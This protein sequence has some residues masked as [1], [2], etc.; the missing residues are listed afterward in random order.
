MRSRGILLAACAAS[1]LMPVSGHTQT[2]AAN[3]AEVEATGGLAEIVVTAQKR[4]E[5]AQRVPIAISAF[6]S[7]A[8]QAKGVTELTQI[9]QLAPNV[10]LDSGTPFSGSSSTL[11]AYIRG[12]GQNDFAL[13]LDPGVGIY[14]DGVYLARTVGANADLAD[15]ERVEILKGPQGTL[16]GRNSIGGAISIVTRAP[17]KE[18]GV[19]GSITTG[20]YDRLDVSLSADLPI[21]ETLRSNLTF[22]SRKRDG[23]QR[24]IPLPTT[25][26]YI[27]DGDGFRHAGYDRSSTQGGTNEWTARGKLL[28]EAAPSLRLTLAGDYTK[29]DQQ[30]SAQSLLKVYSSAEVAALGAGAGLPFGALTPS[31]PSANNFVEIYNRC[32]SETPAQLARPVFAPFPPGFVDLTAVC[33]ERGVPA[34]ARNPLGRTSVTSALGS[35]NVDADPGNNRLPYDNRFIA[36]NI[37]QTYANGL[38]FSKLRSWG[39]SGTADFNLSDHA[40]LKSITAYREL[41]WSTGGDQD[42]SP[43]QILEFSF[44]INQQQFSQELQ[45]TGDLMDGRLK[46]VFGGYYFRESGNNQDYVTLPGGL[47]Q[48]DGNNLL[49]TKSYAG[50]THLNFDSTDWLSFTAGA[51][52]SVER[53]SFEGF[54]TELN[55]FNYKLGGIPINGLINVPCD[56][57]GPVPPSDICD[58]AQLVGFPDA[59]NVL[60]YVPPVVFRKKFNIFTPRLGF[61][62]K[63]STRLMV[64]GSYSKGFKSGGWTTRFNNPTPFQT[65]SDGFGPERAT[66]WELGVKSEWLNRHLLVNVSGFYTNYDGIQLTT[67]VNGVTATAR[68][69]GDAELYGV[70]VESRAVI[71]RAFSIAANI[72]YIHARYTRKL[73]GTNAGD[74]LPKTP[75]FKFNIGPQYVADLG[76]KGSLTF[77]ADYTHT[78]SEFNNTENSAILTRPGVDMLNASITYNSPDRHWSLT[79]GASNILDQRYITTGFDNPGIGLAAGTY[80]A[81]RQWY[82]TLGVKF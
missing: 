14:L 19:R 73:P 50:Y 22:S 45:L 58:F 65:V 5:S 42:G 35:V 40:A 62:I 4:S 69:A 2:A 66:S 11:A 21:S 49:R 37:D 67:L 8:L 76:D 29:Q 13:N 41:K 27:T 10:S 56:N 63:P 43:L 82:A 9:A 47:Q 51:R 71:S 6:T 52:Y 80:S 23:Y 74:R 44:E 53:K 38:S 33:G 57:A 59:N 31:G 60:R 18:F 20:S 28:W 30:G 68:N 25:A 7:D 55:G 79:G 15:V 39:L 78:S 24:R 77:S 26:A 34:G 32:I 72:G 61:E 64:Y 46:Y 17:G 1:A 75:E 81:P 48:V 16:F 3:S 54:Q 70:E 36:P 12:I